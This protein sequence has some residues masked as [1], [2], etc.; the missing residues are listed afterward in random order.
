MEKVYGMVA[1]ILAKVFTAFI[2]AEA[3]NVVSQVHLAF[4]EYIIRKKQI[5]Q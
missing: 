2:H 1:M 4:T 3:A 5:S